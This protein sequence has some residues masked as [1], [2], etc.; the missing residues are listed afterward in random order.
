MVEGEETAAE[1]A[2]AAWVELGF[3]GCSGG[4][5]GPSILLPITGYLGYPNNHRVQQAGA[6]G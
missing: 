2:A 3:G 5:L 1:A 6:G 4:M